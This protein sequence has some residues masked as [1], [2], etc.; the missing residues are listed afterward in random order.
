MNSLKSI[1]LIVLVTG[2]VSCYP[3]LGKPDSRPAEPRFDR[4]VA[5]S[6]ETIIEGEP[7]STLYSLYDGYIVWKTGNRF[8]VR[9][10]KELASRQTIKYVYSGNI[11][12]SNAL[13]DQFVKKHEGPFDRIIQ[14][15]HNI[16]FEFEFFPDERSSDRGFEFSLIPLFPE[17]CITFDLL[18]NGALI[19]ERIRLGSSF[20]APRI[21]PITVCF[22]Q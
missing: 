17:Y 9:I 4:D 8:H 16:S 22:R 18:I 12:A 3:L 7:D 21:V 14:R 6:Y 11:S 13:I 19:P 15:E 5:F 10:I 20:Y 2:M 1:V